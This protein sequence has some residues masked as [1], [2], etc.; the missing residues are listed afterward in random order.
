MIERVVIA[1][2]EIPLEDVFAAL[3]IRHGRGSVDDAPLASTATLSLVNVTRELSSSFRVG[4]ELELELA[5]GVRRFSGRITDAGYVAGTLAIIAVSSLSWLARRKVGAVDYPE[6]AWSSRVYRV[7]REAGIGSSWSEREGTWAEATDTWLE[8]ETE[9]ELELGEYDPT[10]AARPAQETTLGAYLAELV[11]SVPAAIAQLPNGAILVQ[12]LT[13]RKSRPTF[14]LDPAKV[15]A[16]P[17]WAQVDEIANVAKVEWA[18]GEVVELEPVSHARFEEREATF[19]TE[20]ADLE[21]AEDRADRETARRAMPRWELERLELLDLEPAIGIGTPVVVTELEAGAPAASYFGVVEGWE[22]QL[23]PNPRED[24]ID[25]S[26]VLTLSP[27]RY[28]GIGITWAAV[29]AVV[30]WA[31]AGAATWNEPELALTD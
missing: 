4:D 27:P 22:D 13:A 31:T 21:E 16:D 11:E 19:R 30:T 9:L 3:T 24:S 5:A 25:W 1:G 8:A 20:L 7:I 23:E 14:S 6:E 26:M 10:L 17:E 12:E 15:A 28:S 2:A 29:P 18:G